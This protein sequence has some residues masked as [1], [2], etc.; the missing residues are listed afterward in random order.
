M[1]VGINETG[2]FG[3]AINV[4]VASA[5]SKR[6]Q[7]GVG[8]QLFDKATLSNNSGEDWR[9]VAL[10][11]LPDAVTVQEGEEFDNPFKITNDLIKGRPV[12]VGIEL[13]F[14]DKMKRRLDSKALAQTGSLAGNSMQRK[15][16]KDCITQLDSLSTSFGGTGVTFAS[17]YI[18]ASVAQIV[19]NATERGVA[20]I[21]TLMH[22]FQIRALRA[23][24]IGGVGTYPIPEGIS[25][26]VLEGGYTGLNIA[27]SS[28]FMDAVTA[29]DTSGDFKGATFAKEAM[30]LVQGKSLYREE[31]RLPGRRATAVFMFDEY[32]T[33]ERA[34]SM[35]VEQYF[36]APAPTS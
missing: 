28:V 29:P 10:D 11:R 22:P 15:K 18:D 16:A 26:R 8:P 13:I 2:G 6:E 3:S 17:G 9:E 19:G 5:R 21:Y 12:E 32:V 1:T 33:V 35:G 30:V 34:D 14:T 20:P 36:D 7:D 4:M 25:Q 31:E 27:G 23:D 24:L